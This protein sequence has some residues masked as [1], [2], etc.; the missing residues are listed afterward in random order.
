MPA[1]I[2]RIVLCVVLSL[3][4]VVAVP[5]GGAQ[6]GQSVP[7]AGQ[8]VEVTHVAS[9]LAQNGRVD[10]NI[11]NTG[12]SSARYRVEFEGLSARESTVATGDWWRLPI[13]GRPDDNFDVTVRRDGVV[14]S[15]T[16]VAISCDRASPALSAPEIQV[17]NACRAGLGYLI[18]Q[19]VNNTSQ[20]R[21]YVVAFE[22]V[23]NRSTTAAPFGQSVRAVTGRRDGTYLAT[24][25]SQGVIVASF[26]VVVDCGDSG[27]VVDSEPPSAPTDFIV[28]A[29]QLQATSAGVRWGA[30]SDNVGVTWYRMFLDGVQV[31]AVPFDASGYI[32][33]GLD[34]STTYT[35]GVAALDAAGNSSAISEAGVTTPVL[36]GDTGEGDLVTD[37]IVA[38]DIRLDPIG[39]SNGI[40]VYLSSPR[41]SNSSNRG[42]CGWEEN[43]NGR[44]FNAHAA[45][46]VHWQGEVQESGDPGF[47]LRNLRR[48][49][50]RVI[51]GSNPRDDGLNDNVR[52]SDLAGAD[53]HLVTHTNSLEGCG[54]R[55]GN[56]TLSMWREGSPQTGKDLAE[57]MAATLDVVVPGTKRADPDRLIAGVS[58]G[59][60]RDPAAPTR[61]YNEVIFHDNQTHVDWFQGGGGVGD[62]VREGA[63]RYG[64]ALDSFFSSP[65]ANYGLLSSVPGFGVTDT[66]RRRDDVIAAWESYQTQAAAAE[67][68]SRAGYQLR[69]ESNQPAATVAEVARAL[70]VRRSADSSAD[71][72]EEQ[73]A[74]EINRSFRAGLSVSERDGFDKALWGHDTATLSSYREAGGSA[75]PTDFSGGCWGESKAA[76]TGVWELRR[77]VLPQIWEHLGRIADDPASLLRT[78]FDECVAGFTL[79]ASSPTELEELIASGSELAADAFTACSP[80][81]TVEFAAAR[82]EVEG[83]LLSGAVGQRL[84]AQQVRY[85]NALRDAAADDGFVAFLSSAAR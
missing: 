71:E 6:G 10:T 66:D 21:P 54:N 49:G 81:W 20:P 4:G 36:P 9:C 72:V 31:A 63:W 34:P 3:T 1:R 82:A 18:F 47:E 16:T 5:S 30:S 69:P 59:E 19:F 48:R 85:R 64:F 13:T 60:L 68:M 46:G 40:T 52:R 53:V 83:E 84:R 55:A 70:G 27:S 28:R 25:T 41:H 77:E 8:A 11:V 29:D 51:V 26:A 61:V 15:Q 74:Q 2:R 45:N 22:G 75:N 14:V 12:A 79:V 37:V 58:L 76:H 42:E 38:N 73:T 7:G 67:C 39:P 35:F 56:Y 80:I 43:I 78:R 44:H 50:Y 65:A 62:G 57:I 23:G 17:V 32:F 24:I 33:D